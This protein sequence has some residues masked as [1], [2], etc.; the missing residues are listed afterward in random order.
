MA[1]GRG[2]GGHPS[3]PVAVKEVLKEMLQGDLQG[4]E[5]RQRLRRAWEAALPP[6]LLAQTRLADW[7]RGEL[8]VEV[9]AAVVGQELQFLKPRLLKALESALG[10]GAVRDL[11]IRVGDGF[12]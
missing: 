3:R 8:W 6:S 1:R 5:A 4:L 9:A 12:S 11:R 7:R 10:P 2:K